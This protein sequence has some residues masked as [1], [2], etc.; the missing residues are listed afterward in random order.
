LQDVVRW[1]AEGPARLAGRGHRKGTIAEGYDA[2]LVVFAPEQEFLVTEDRL[3][4]RHRVS[5]YL[6]ELL[7]GV[8]E[9]TFVR[10]TCVFDGGQFPGEPRGQECQR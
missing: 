8:V 5:P 9:K 7:N 10:G 3:H 6:G 4:F 1:M 2:D